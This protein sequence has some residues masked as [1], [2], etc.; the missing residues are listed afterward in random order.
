MVNSIAVYFAP[1]ISKGW[2]TVELV[3]AVIG[4]EADSPFD[5]PYF[6]STGLEFSIPKD[7]RIDIR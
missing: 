2:L 3:Q 1:P 4:V 5:A 7:E 6:V